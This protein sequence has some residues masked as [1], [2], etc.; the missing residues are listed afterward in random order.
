MYSH[1]SQKKM[2][3]HTYK[4]KK[5]QQPKGDFYFLYFG[6]GTDKVWKDILF[7]SKEVWEDTGAEAECACGETLDLDIVILNMD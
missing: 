5:Q 2:Y 7:F 6:N 4:G 3:S 1:S